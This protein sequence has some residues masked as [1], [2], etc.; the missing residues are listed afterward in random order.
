MNLTL[1][2][3]PAVAA[4]GGRYDYTYDGLPEVSVDAASIT[5][6]TSN[7]ST[8]IAFNVIHSVTGYRTCSD[9]RKRFRIELKSDSGDLY[10]FEFEVSGS[11]TSY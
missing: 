9:F 2:G 6:T 5:G 10:D 7:Y 11:L 3:T 8:Q 1:S 4:I